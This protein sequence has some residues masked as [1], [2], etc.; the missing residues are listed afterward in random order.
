MATCTSQL[1]PSPKATSS[2]IHCAGRKSATNDNIISERSYHVEDGPDSWSDT[3]SDQSLSVSETSSTVLDPSVAE[4]LLSVCCAKI[5]DL[6]RNEILASDFIADLQ[7][8]GDGGIS[9]QARQNLLVWLMHFNA[10]FGLAPDSFAAAASMVDSVLERTIVKPEHADLL[11]VACLRIASKM[12]GAGALQP[13][14]AEICINCDHQFSERDLA[15]MESIVCNKLA[16]KFRKVVPYDFVD[17]MVQLCNLMGAPAVAST[18]AFH[19]VFSTR[20]LTACFHYELLSF[21]P[22]T[23]ALAVLVFELDRIASDFDSSLIAARL[24]S[25]M[26]IFDWDLHNCIKCLSRKFSPSASYEGKGSGERSS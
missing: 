12:V 22:S 16:G 21:R 26:D 1:S 25:I 6:A 20:L 8:D 15:R 7:R 4:D 24:G 11:G 13:T 18:G 19:S 9:E 14:P 3:L 5:R 23:I 10:F 17:D 2:P